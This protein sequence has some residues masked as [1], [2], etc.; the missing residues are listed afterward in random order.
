MPKKQ[1]AAACCTW[2]FRGSRKRP[3]SVNIGCARISGPIFAGA[4][5]VKPAS[6]DAPVFLPN[7]TTVARRRCPILQ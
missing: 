7:Q 1:R 2:L 6:T 5:R 3:T 4:S